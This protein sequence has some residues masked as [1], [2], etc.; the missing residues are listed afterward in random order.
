L[1]QLL[2]DALSQPE[3]GGL[4]LIWQQGK[5]AGHCLSNRR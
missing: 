5:E 1:L 2:H 4:L 3:V